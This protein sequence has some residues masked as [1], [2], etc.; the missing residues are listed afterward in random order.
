MQNIYF[1]ADTH[2]GHANIIKYCH[3]P[4]LNKSEMDQVLLDN[5]NSLVQPNDILYHLGDF[6]FGDPI[7][8]RK[9]IK[10]K[11]IFFIYGNH[12]KNIMYDNQVQTYFKWCK[13]YHELTIDDQLIVL[14]HYSMNV[15]NKSHRSSYQLYG[16]SH[17]SLPDN[18]NALSIDVGIDTCL[19]EHKQYYPYSLEEINVI[20]KTYKTYMPID[21]HV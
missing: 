9:Q 10:C 20:M 14:M 18:I 16:H 1:T 19:F 7:F 11:N 5:I 2:F 4:F 15:W 8:Y 21:H 13:H 6:A 12:D 3:R 17:G